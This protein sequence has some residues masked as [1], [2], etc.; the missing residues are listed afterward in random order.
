MIKWITNSVFIDVDTGEILP[1]TNVK[2][3]KYTSYKLINKSK[4]TLLDEN[5]K[6]G[7]IRI[8][9]ECKHTG[10]REIKFKD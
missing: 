10:Q 7:T 6:I 9:N 8:T 5:E 2:Q 3:L 4:K 1:Y